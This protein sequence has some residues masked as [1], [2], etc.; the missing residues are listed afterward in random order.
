M[1]LDHPQRGLL[2]AALARGARGALVRNVAG[3][4][5]LELDH[6]LPERLRVATLQVFHQRPVKTQRILRVAFAPHEG[7][8]G[9]DAV[10]LQVLVKVVP[11][12]CRRKWVALRNKRWQLLRAVR[13]LEA[14][15]HS[16]SQLLEVLRHAEDS[17]LSLL[18][19]ALG[20][21][22]HALLHDPRLRPA[23]D[24]P[25]RRVRDRPAARAG[26]AAPQLVDL[27]PQLLQVRA[28][29]R[30]LGEVFGI[31]PQRLHGVGEM[32]QRNP[33]D[34]G[35]LKHV[36]RGAHENECAQLRRDDLLIGKE[37]LHGL[38]ATAAEQAGDPLAQLAQLPQHGAHGLHAYAA[39][40][41]SAERRGRR[42]LGEGLGLRDGR[43]Q[44]RR[45]RAPL[46]RHLAQLL[47]HPQRGAS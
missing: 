30:P 8:V 9:R 14:D 38:L 21:D 15:S 16:A 41:Q 42:E 36:A 6:A 29:W 34:I 5:G 12:C 11:R 40:R 35:S 25:L 3:E 44:Q 31:P 28:G 46:L 47:A 43:L 19:P 27:V 26:D 22:L 32:V 17:L 2:D 10:R 18:P 24:D 39:L 7:I 33:S 13:D 1:H 23:P 20:D 4:E 45:G 37:P